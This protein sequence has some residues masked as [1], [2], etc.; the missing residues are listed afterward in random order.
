MNFMIV[1]FASLARFRKT[2]QLFILQVLNVLSVFLSF[3]LSYGSEKEFKNI[4]TYIQQSM[5]TPDDCCL[6]RIL[7]NF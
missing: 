6:L 2:A 1:D 4:P 5:F 3:W 7:Q